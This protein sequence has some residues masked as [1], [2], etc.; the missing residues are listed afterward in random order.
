MW[1]IRERSSMGPV[2]MW[3]RQP[4]CPREVSYSIG[5]WFLWLRFST[6][7]NTYKEGTSHFWLS[8]TFR[9]PGE[10]SDT[11]VQHNW[12]LFPTSLLRVKLLKPLQ[13]STLVFFFMIPY[14]VYLASSASHLSCHDL[15]LLCRYLLTVNHG[16]GIPAG[17]INR[18]IWNIG[19]LDW[20]G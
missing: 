14:S 11:S 4:I 2:P 7:E 12:S 1:L 8:D 16:T 18:S 5:R 9:Y 15:Q 17:R 19:T 10:V 13:Y 20:L 6:E 3:S